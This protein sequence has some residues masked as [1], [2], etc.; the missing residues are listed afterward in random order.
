MMNL[1]FCP[2][3]RWPSEN[4][5]ICLVCQLRR[6]HGP[7]TYIE[8]LL[9]TILSTD[10]SRVGMAIDILTKK[11]KEPR[12]IIPM[13]VLIK[14]SEY[15]ERLVMAARGLGRLNDR[16]AVPYLANLLED[17]RKPFVARI[18]SAETLG[19][20]GGRQARQTLERAVDVPVSFLPA[21][22]PLADLP[23]SLSPS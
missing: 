13:L 12:A 6:E 23:Q 16:A 21:L 14:N 10:P 22:I 1:Y 4:E 18:A 7:N 11:M 17:D 2:K 5:D 19:S 15:P 3:C 9:E 8:K 20:L